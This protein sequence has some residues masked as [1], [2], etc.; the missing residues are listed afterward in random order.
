MLT[1]YS[2]PELFGVADN[3]PFGLKVYAFMK[4]CGLSFRHEH[5]LDASKAPRGQL[6]YL[7]DGEAVIG[8]SDAIID[9]LIASRGLDID[10][11]LTAAQRDIH[12]MVRRTLDD[13]YWV[14]SYSRWKDDRFWPQF[15]DAMLGQH[16]GIPAEALEKAREYNFQRYHFQGIGRYAP[17]AV[18]ARGIADL[19]V[20]ANLIPLDGFA[21]GGRPTSIDAAIYG[22]TANIYFSNINTPV[23]LYLY[24][25]KNL[26]GH[27]EAV[28]AALR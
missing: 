24:K 15:R 27:C 28:H 20:L 2:Y 14:M 1:L 22:F 16:P 18:Y 7:V 17:E 21:F 8:D 23:T 12:L 6:P 11:A 25:Q 3:N 26:V 13:L 19:A 4:L 10:A 9:H 5:V